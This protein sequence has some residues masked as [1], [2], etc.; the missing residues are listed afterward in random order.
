MITINLSGSSTSKEPELEPKLTPLNEVQP[1]GASFSERTLERFD[2]RLKLFSHSSLSLLNSCPRKYQL[3]KLI[4]REREQSI[5]LLYGKAFGAGIQSYLVHRSLEEAYLQ[6]AI[7]WDADL[8][9]YEL[10]QFEKT[11]WNCLVAIEQFS[12]IYRESLSCKLSEYE[13][14]TLPSGKLSVEVSLRIKLPNGFYHR[15]HIDIILQHKETKQLLVVD[16]KTSNA[17]YVNFNKYV[18]SGQLL[19]YSIVLSTLFPDITD[20]DVLYYEY[21]T[22]LRRFESH[23]QTVTNYNKAKYLKNLVTSTKVVMLYEETCGDEG[24]PQNGNACNNFGRPCTLISTCGLS[25]SSLLSFG[26]KLET[27]DAKELDDIIYDIDL[28][29]MDILNGLES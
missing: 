27:R 7:N 21:L 28:D 19:S 29:L 14:F 23:I 10:G 9:Y 11:F 16:V 4:G 1:N 2:S 13:V 25:N 24:Y 5:H 22:A 3:T 18:N 26:Y 17:K 8:D 15:G 6:A 12:F 20:F